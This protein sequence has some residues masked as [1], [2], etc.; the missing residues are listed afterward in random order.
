MTPSE[1]RWNWLT[2]V[3]AARTAISR[4]VAGTTE[5]VLSAGRPV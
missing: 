5:A 2:A 1:E 3:I 4:P